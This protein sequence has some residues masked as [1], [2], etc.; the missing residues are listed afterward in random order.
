VPENDD[1]K[2]IT[3]V[4]NKKKKTKIVKVANKE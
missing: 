1:T 2:I 3:N 4:K